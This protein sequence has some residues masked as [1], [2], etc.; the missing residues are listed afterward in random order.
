[1]TRPIL[2]CM[3][4][5]LATLKKR[6]PTRKPKA[7]YLGPDDWADFMASASERATVRVAFGNNPRVWRDEPAFNDVPVRESRNVPPRQSRLYDDTTTG[8]PIRPVPSK[9]QRDLERSDIPADQVF[10][11]LD[12]ISRT[13][14][15][16]EHE[17]I[18]LEAAMNGRVILTKRDAAR[19][20]IKRKAART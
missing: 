8:H 16:T 10:A 19:L 20:G 18:A 3:A 17:S 4:D 14:A 7:F 12:Q 6:W 2:D 11:A 15:L 1:M 9:K 5:A 13:R